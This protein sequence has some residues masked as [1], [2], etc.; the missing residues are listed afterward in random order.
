MKY[1]C[2]AYGLITLILII[3]EINQQKAAFKRLANYLEQHLLLN[4][5]QINSAILYSISVN[6]RW[7][8]HSLYMNSLSHFNEEWSSFFKNL[9]EQNMVIMEDLKFIASQIEEESINE[10][11]LIEIYVYKFEETEKF[12]FTL[13]NLFSYIIN[14]GIK[15]MDTF[16]YF[17]V[18]DCGDI[19]EE[20]GLNEINLKNLIEKAYDLYNLDLNFYSDKD[21][22]KKINNNFEY[23]PISLI[24]SG[25]M[26]LCILSFCIYYTIS[27]HN[28]E[29]YF[30]DKLINFNST[31]FDNYITKLDQIKKKLRNDNNDEEDKGDDMD[32]NELDTKKKDE[33]EEEGNDTTN[34]KNSTENNGKKKN[35][36]K[37][38]NKQNKIQQQRRKKLNLMVSFFRT[39][40]I[41][42][43]AK[44]I[45]ILA[46]SLLYYILSIFIKSKYKN[47]YIDRKSVV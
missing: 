1:L 29:I 7:L 26:L 14:N 3:V 16:D 42:F 10:K 41:L 24:I 11:F 40:N 19:P 30:L 43:E 46:F 27:F 31:N 13:D 20:L 36:K 12:N 45:L 38:K 4:K 17:I 44:I 2:Y 35:I 33:D 39:K 9:L 47:E 28:F 22:E 21:K 6:I 37:D 32:L 34:K 15:L 23:V 18:N 25:I 5:I 8:S